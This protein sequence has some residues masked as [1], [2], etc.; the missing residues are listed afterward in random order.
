MAYSSINNILKEMSQ[1]E[2]AR[3]T[4]DAQGLEINE[5]RVNIAILYADTMIDASL[6]G[7]Y[8]VPFE[9]EI[10]PLILKLSVDLAIA[11]L[12]EFAF[13]KSSIP[14]TVYKRKQNA[15]DILK[16]LQRGNINLKASN[17][18][19]S[20][21]PVIISNKSKSKRIFDDD[22]LDLFTEL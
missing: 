2:L 12:Y 16:E 1:S 3:L 17:P 8:E 7:R 5:G 19:T 4:G 18:G 10:E 20:S 14:L 15:L 13:S 6:L 22:K 9:G 11:N 21:P